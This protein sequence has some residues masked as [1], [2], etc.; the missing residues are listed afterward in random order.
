MVGLRFLVAQEKYLDLPNQLTYLSY[1]SF[2]TTSILIILEDSAIVFLA[3]WFIFF[4]FYQFIMGKNIAYDSGSDLGIRMLNT[5]FGTSGKTLVFTK[6]CYALSH[7]LWSTACSLSTNFP[8]K[9]YNASPRGSTEQR[10]G[11]RWFLFFRA[12]HT[13]SYS[14][15]QSPRNVL[16]EL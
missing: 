9:L 15:V 3:L 10:A 5:Y 14:F 1:K 2:N 16:H 12:T 13:L 6:S 7:I 8:S 4:S 11:C